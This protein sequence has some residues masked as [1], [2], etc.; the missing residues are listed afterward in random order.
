M[1]YGVRD[2]RYSSVGLVSGGDGS[3]RTAFYNGR[4]STEGHCFRFEARC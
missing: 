1:G 2:D 4:E 3:I